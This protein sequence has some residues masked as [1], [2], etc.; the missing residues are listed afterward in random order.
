MWVSSLHLHAAVNCVLYDIHY[1][2]Y[3]VLCTDNVYC[4][5]YTIAYYTPK[6]MYILFCY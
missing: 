2:L 5:V 1:T 4:M 3:I 6:A